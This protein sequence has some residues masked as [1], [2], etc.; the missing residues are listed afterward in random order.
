MPGLCPSML[1]LRVSRR[2]WDQPHHVQSAPLR[3]EP[4]ACFSPGSLTGISRNFSIMLPYSWLT[5][6][7]AKVLCCL[8]GSNVARPGCWC[9]FVLSV[10]PPGARQSA[11]SLCV[12]ARCLTPLPAAL[13]V[14]WREGN[15]RV[16]TPHVP[17]SMP[18][19][20]CFAS[21]KK[22]HTCSCFLLLLLPACLCTLAVGSAFAHSKHPADGISFFWQMEE[23]VWA[24]YD[25]VAAPTQGNP[26][27]SCP[28]LCLAVVSHSANTGSLAL[29]QKGGRVFLRTMVQECTGPTEW[30]WEQGEPCPYH[31]CRI[32]LGMPCH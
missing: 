4:R 27:R 14:S 26:A 11:Q 3:G 23:A 2:S 19:G 8:A 21:K 12:A 1:G 28:Q 13:G 9:V 32:A 30:Q 7:S 20:E 24:A 18:H 15:Q 29:V 31:S 25:G 16:R 6:G 5:R 22:D 10:W 17:K